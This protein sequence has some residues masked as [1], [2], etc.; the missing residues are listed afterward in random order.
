MLVDK[1]NTWLFH[2]FTQH[3]G[4]RN[5]RFMSANSLMQAKKESRSGVSLCELYQS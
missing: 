3:V 1:V 4:A 5:R 2:T